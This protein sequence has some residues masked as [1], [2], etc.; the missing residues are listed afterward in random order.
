MLSSCSS[1]QAAKINFGLPGKLQHCV[2][3]SPQDM[4]QPSLTCITY[5]QCWSSGGISRAGAG[6]AGRGQP[7]PELGSGGHM[8]FQTCVLTVLT[9]WWDGAFIRSPSITEFHVSEV[10]PPVL[11]FSIPCHIT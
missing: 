9:L 5:A 8:S 6:G 2:T 7:G 11:N 4:H 1:G 3:W 10:V